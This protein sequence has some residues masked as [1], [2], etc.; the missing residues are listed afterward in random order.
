LNAL[1][2]ANAAARRAEE[3]VRDLETSA[4]SGPDGA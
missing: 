4:E 2:A 3:V 1:P